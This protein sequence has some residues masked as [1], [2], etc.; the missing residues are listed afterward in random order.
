[1]SEYNSAYWSTVVAQGNKKCNLILFW[2][3]GE[4]KGEGIGLGRGGGIGTGTE[5]HW[6]GEANSNF[7]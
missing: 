2:R 3:E 4:G 7:F 1:M 6:N 5:V